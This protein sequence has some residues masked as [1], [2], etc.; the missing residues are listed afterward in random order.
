PEKCRKLYFTVCDVNFL[1][2]I[3]DNY[4]HEMGDKAIIRCAE[5]LL[6]V[7][8]KKGK[9]YR[10]GGDEF[11]CIVKSDLTQAIKTEFLIEA[12]RYKGYPF[13]VAVGTSHYDKSIDFD[14]PSTKT[15]LA[16]SD[17]EMYNHKQE[18]KKFTKEFQ[19]EGR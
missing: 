15:I 19:H 8:S 7:V 18:I 16:R 2:Y 12:S 17:K 6:K 9:V 5:V 13:S 1:K 14:N 3:N 10:T 11:I 4:G